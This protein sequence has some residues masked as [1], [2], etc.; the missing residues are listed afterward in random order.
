MIH[1]VV[2]CHCNLNG[3]DLNCCLRL[4][5]MVMS[6]CQVANHS[7]VAAVHQRQIIDANAT[8]LWSD[9]DTERCRHH[10]RCLPQTD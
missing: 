8:Q 7:T 4:A 2:V 5:A 6:R 1:H 9:A 3:D 10:E